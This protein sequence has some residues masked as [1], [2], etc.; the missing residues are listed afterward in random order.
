MKIVWFRIDDRFVHGQVTVAWT[1]ISNANTIW[2][3]NDSIAKNPVLKQLQIS[4][5][6]PGTAVEVFTVDDAIKKL[7][8][9]T[10]A[11]DNKRVL[12]IVSNP[13]DALKLIEAGAKVEFINVGQMAWKRGR[14][15]IDKTVSVT[16][17]EAAACKKIAEMGVKLLY[18]QLPDFPPK[19][20]DFIEK[21]KKKGLI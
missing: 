5:A 9:E 6:P 7:Q 11:S 19:P 16:P 4:L 17:E 21:L 13:I 8:E 10:N 12:L 3:V 20:E 18:Q 15:K 1:K 2:V 14:E